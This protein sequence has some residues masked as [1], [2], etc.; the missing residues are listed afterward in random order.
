[1]VLLFYLV[2]YYCVHTYSTCCT[3]EIAFFRILRRSI[4]AVVCQSRPESFKISYLWYLAFA[5]VRCVTVSCRTRRFCTILFFCSLFL[6]F[7]WI[8]FCGFLTLSVLHWPWPRWLVPLTGTNHSI[9]K[10][11]RITATSQILPTIKTTHPP[12]HQ[13][14]QPKPRK[15]RV[16]RNRGRMRH[17]SAHDRGRAI[18]VRNA[19]RRPAVFVQ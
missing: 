9:Q 4:S 6:L 3:S 18:I 13:P 19:I 8:R 5:K 15:D 14:R 1:M 12:W 10:T 11:K 7:F 16:S 17:L 2:L